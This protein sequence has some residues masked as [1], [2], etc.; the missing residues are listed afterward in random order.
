VLHRLAA[1]S[2]QVAQEQCD[3]LGSDLQE[4]QLMVE[5]HEKKAL[6]TQ[7]E[8]TV[9]QQ[10]LTRLSLVCNVASW[11]GHTFPDIALVQYDSLSSSL[12]AQ[13]WWLLC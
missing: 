11:C 2:C 9:S 10:L 5:E 4:A 7:Q 1:V 6:T 8:V 12:A 3:A 13:S